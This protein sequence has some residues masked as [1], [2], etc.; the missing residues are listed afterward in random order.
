MVKVL[1][2]LALLVML[3]AAMKQA[4]VVATLKVPVRRSGG[5]GF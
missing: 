4:V 3:Q 5:P 2:L 1:L